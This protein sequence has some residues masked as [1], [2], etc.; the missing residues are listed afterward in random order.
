LRLVIRNEIVADFYHRGRMP[1]GH[2]VPRH[3]VVDAIRGRVGLIDANE[4]FGLRAKFCNERFTNARVRSKDHAAMPRPGDSAEAPRKRVNRDQS[5][6]T[7]LPRAS[8]K[9]ILD[10]GVIGPVNL[11][12]AAMALCSRKLR[13]SRHRHAVRRFDN[14]IDIRGITI[15]VNDQSGNASMNKRRIQQFGETAADGERA[16]ILCEMLAQIGR[17]QPE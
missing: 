7:P 5:A 14:G 17:G 4:Q 10:R 12:G 2:T 9:Q 6:A 1:V 8:D 15:D 16:G 13:V 11:R 3:R